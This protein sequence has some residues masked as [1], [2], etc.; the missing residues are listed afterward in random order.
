[1]KEL[2]V[3]GKRV[4]LIDETGVWCKPNGKQWRKIDDEIIC[5]K[6]QDES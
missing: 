5:K 6:D 2:L 4:Y 1:M 3:N